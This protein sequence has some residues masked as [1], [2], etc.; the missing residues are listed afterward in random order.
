MKTCSDSIS[1][2]QTR[3]TGLGLILLGIYLNIP[4]SVLGLV[5]SYPGILR[6]P[7]GE[8]LT[9]FEAG[10]PV[11]LAVWYAFLLAALAMIVLAG[12]ARRL[13]VG[14]SVAGMLAGVLQA[15]GLIRW[16]FVVPGLA[17]AYT[18]PGATAA[19]R[20]T[21][22]VVFDAVHAYA[23]VAVGEHLGQLATAVWAVLFASALFDAHRIR[24]WQLRLAWVA[25]GLILVGLAEGF[26]TVLP[27]DPGVLGVATPM[28]FI[29]L[30]AWMV[31]AGVTLFRGGGVDSL[32]FQASS[33]SN[34]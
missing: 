1:G 10:G 24:R 6:R 32:R 4:F 17:R 9:R 18:A 3:R 8:I 27:F 25:A 2:G 21:V 5:F 15:I 19:T 20:E 12:M 23:G 29:V 34:A 30:S 7:S 28:G 33:Q 22:T 13:G 31:L 14:A 26:A 16:V 11:L